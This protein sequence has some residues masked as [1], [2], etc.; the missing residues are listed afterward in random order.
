[1]GLFPSG[2]SLDGLMQSLPQL[3]KSLGIVFTEIGERHLA[4]AC[5]VTDMF[6]QPHGIMHGG[7]SC[8]IGESLGSIAG[9]LSLHGT[10]KRAVGQNLNALHLRPALPG[11]RLRAVAEA[12]HLGNKTQIWEIGISDADKQKAIAKITLTLALI[13]AHR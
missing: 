9:N 3:E 4:I 8:L 10:A 1:M 6:L 11:T 2:L 13:D 12:L 7:V 5:T